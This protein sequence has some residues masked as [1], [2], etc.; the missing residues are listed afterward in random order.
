MPKNLRSFL[1]LVLRSFSEEEKRKSI[2]REQ[3]KSESQNPKSETKKS[4]SK[5]KKE[6]E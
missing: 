1:R 3:P 6:N 5:N 4:T 2:R